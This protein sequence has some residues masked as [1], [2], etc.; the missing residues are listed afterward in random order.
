MVC[1]CDPPHEAPVEFDDLCAF[2][3]HHAGDEDTEALVKGIDNLTEWLAP[4]QVEAEIGYVVENLDP[5]WVEAHEGK[6][7]DLTDLL[8]VAFAT[9]YDHGL[10]RMLKLILHDD[11]EAHLDAEGRVSS[12]RTYASDHKCFID[13]SCDYVAYDTD[14]ILYY[15]LGIEAVVKFRSDL[16][17]VQTA[18]GPVVI[19][20]NW[21]TAPSDFNWDW[22]NLFLSYYMGVLVE[23]EP[24]RVERTEATWMLG[25]FADAP[26]PLDM[27]LAMTLDTMINSAAGFKTGLTN[28]YGGPENP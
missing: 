24:G 3:F 1:S 4:H 2:V 9:R 14:A 20:R 15:P 11:E 21:L 6:P 17:R 18:K 10:E 12:K 7:Y 23:Y 27:A 25:E 22:I 28:E 8:G 26:L 16:R 5:T 13:G 19:T